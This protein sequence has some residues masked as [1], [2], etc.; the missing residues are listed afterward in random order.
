MTGFTKDYG[1]VSSKTYLLNLHAA[2]RAVHECHSGKNRIT[3][4]VRLCVGLTLH[5]AAGRS[6]FLP[7]EVGSHPARRRLLLHLA[8][9][10]LSRTAGLAAGANPL[11]RELSFRL[12]PL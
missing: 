6:V 2:L 7:G 8:A 1:S 10:D 9:D 3:G 12:C 11:Y 5:G 4:S